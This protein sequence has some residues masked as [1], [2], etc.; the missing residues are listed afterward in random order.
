MVVGSALLFLNNQVV[1]TR[2]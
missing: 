1:W 2:F